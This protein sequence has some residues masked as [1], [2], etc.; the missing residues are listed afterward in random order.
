MTTFHLITFLGFVLWLA[1]FNYL[2]FAAAGKVPFFTFSKLSDSYFFCGAFMIIF[3]GLFVF[4]LHFP[5][6]EELKLIRAA[7]DKDRLDWVRQLMELLATLLGGGVGG[8]LAA[9][10]IGFAREGD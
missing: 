10:A 3:T 6:S 1:I 8:N 4:L 9:S 5:F 7:A 2:I